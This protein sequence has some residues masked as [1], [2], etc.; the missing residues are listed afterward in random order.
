MVS[1]KPS[2]IG[3]ISL[4]ILSLIAGIKGLV[5]ARLASLQHTVVWESPPRGAPRTWM[6]PWQAAVFWTLI[7]LVGFSWLVI[8][9]YKRRRQSDTPSKIPRD[10]I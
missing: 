6:D 8:T 2:L 10:A 7:I 5:V 4:A 3:P 1:A 9:L